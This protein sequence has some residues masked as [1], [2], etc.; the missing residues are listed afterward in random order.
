MQVLFELKKESR[1]KNVLTK[2]YNI[3]FGSILIILT[4]VATLYRKVDSPPFN[5][6]YLSDMMSVLDSS[7]GDIVRQAS[8]LNLEKHILKFEKLSEMLKEFTL[9]MESSREFRT[10]SILSQV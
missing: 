3:L 7:L 4:E 2:A 8:Q 1:N 9:G 10:D 6:S 5:A